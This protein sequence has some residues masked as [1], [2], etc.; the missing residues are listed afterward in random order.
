MLYSFFCLGNLKKVMPPDT[1]VGSD[2]NK[3]SLIVPLKNEAKVIGETLRAMTKIKYP[4]SLYEVLVVVRVDD[5]L[6]IKAVERAIEKMS[7]GVDLPDI[8]LI[9]IDGEPINKA[10]SLNQAFLHASG[11]IISVFDAEDSPSKHILKAVDQTFLQTKVDVVQAGVQLINVASRWFSALN[12]LE[13]YF[14][15]KSILPLMAS[16]GA[17][18]LG[19]NTVFFKKQVLNSIGGWDENCL[20]EDA[21]IG[22]RA[23]AAGFKTKMIYLENLATLEETPQNEAAFIRQRS[24]W[25]QGY[26]QVLLKGDW[27]KLPSLKQQFLSFYLLCQF[28][29]HQFVVLSMISLPLVSLVTKVPLWLALFSWLPAY[30]LALQIGLYFIGLADL[31]KHY[32]LKFKK[33]LYLYLILSYIPYQLMLSLASFRAVFRQLFGLLNWEKTHH[34]NLHRQLKLAS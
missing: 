17:N 22:I 5:I 2:T 34:F 30:F 15:F 29:I 25:D 14:W 7:L 18:P 13:Y 4:K 21:D 32:H 1:L 12:C 6:T 24:R 20:T 10:Y 23:V 3:F 8:K 27:L 16:L 26:L 28:L 9:K 31:K 11:D 19:G 33:S